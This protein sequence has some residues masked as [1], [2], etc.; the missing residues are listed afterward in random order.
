MLN[1]TSP[2][3]RLRFFLHLIPCNIKLWGEKKKTGKKSQMQLTPLHTLGKNPVRWPFDVHTICYAH[4]YTTRTNWSRSSKPQG[5]LISV[6]K[7]GPQRAKSASA[8]AILEASQ[9]L[10]LFVL[11]L[12]TE[13]KTLC[14]L[15]YVPHPPSQVSKI[16]LSVGVSL[17]QG[18]DT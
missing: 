7:S 8:A 4:N 5:H 15:S 12:R 1:S 13:A 10:F 17:R 14:V 3:R 9:I 6:R 2:T 11:M 16:L 18:F